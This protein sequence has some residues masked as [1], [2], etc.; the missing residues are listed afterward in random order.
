MVLQ[1]RKI[2]SRG[3]HVRLARLREESDELIDLSLMHCTT[4]P[5]CFF[6]KRHEQRVEEISAEINAIHRE[7][8]R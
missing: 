1:D 4:Q 6:C 8:S 2:D 7:L 5:I 3:L